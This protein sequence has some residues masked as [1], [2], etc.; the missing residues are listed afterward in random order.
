M[1][2]AV[3]LREE[4]KGHSSTTAVSGEQH[5]KDERCSFKKDG[6]MRDMEVK[7]A[8]SGRKSCGLRANS[9]RQGTMKDAV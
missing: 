7:C 1:R 9:R 2:P 8:L 5:E 4:E 3:K 6:D